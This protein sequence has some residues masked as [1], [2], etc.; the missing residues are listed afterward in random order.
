VIYNSTADGEI[1][2]TVSGNGVAA[3]EDPNE[4]MAAIIASYEASVADGSLIGD[5]PGNSAAGRLKAFGN[6]LNAASDLLN[7]GDLAGACEQLRDTYHR[8]DGLEPPPDFV[9][10]SAR[11]GIAADLLDI[12]SV[13]GCAVY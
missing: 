12:M 11:A 9:T 5:G 10:G 13:L 6:K 3:E 8:A 4:L 7:A 1:M 2:V